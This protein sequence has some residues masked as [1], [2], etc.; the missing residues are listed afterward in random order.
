VNGPTRTIPRTSRPMN[1]IPAR[2]LQGP[3]EGFPASGF[4]VKISD[5]ARAG[6]RN[7]SQG[8]DQAFHFGCLRLSLQR[9]AA[10]TGSIGRDCWSVEQPSAPRRSSCPSDSSAH[11]ESCKLANRSRRLAYRQRQHHPSDAADDHAHTDESAD[12][13]GGTRR[14]LP[15]DHQAQ[16]QSDDS[17]HQHPT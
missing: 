12:R 7:I 2:N 10:K 6:R 9:P 11:F 14:P 5:E 15:V 17:I 4:L 8:R 3:M 1:C 13:P 16:K